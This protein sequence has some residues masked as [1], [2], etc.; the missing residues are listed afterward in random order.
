[1]IFRM[2][3]PLLVKLTLTRET[4]QFLET[5]CSQSFDMVHLNQQFKVYDCFVMQG[6][7]VCGGGRGGEEG[8]GMG[9]T[10]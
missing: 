9:R 3:V 5:K 1:M 2:S 7:C 8:K 4:R 10:N 6:L